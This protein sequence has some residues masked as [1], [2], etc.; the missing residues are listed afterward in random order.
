MGTSVS[1]TAQPTLTKPGFSAR[2]S[3]YLA[4]WLAEQQV[5]LAFSSY[6]TGKLFFVNSDG[7]QLSLFERSFPYCMGLCTNQD[8]S[9]IYL[10][11][12]YQL[13]MLQ[14]AAKGAAE[15][16][17]IPQL[18][19]TTGDLKI[20]DMALDA[21]GQ[22]V[23]VNTLFNGL[24]TVSEGY[25][26][27]PLW[28]PKFISQWAAE[29]RCHLNGLALVDGQPGYVTCI[30]V[31][32]EKHGWRD[33]RATGGVLWHVPSD[34]PVATGLCMPHSPRYYRGKL[35][36]LNAGRGELGYVLPESGRFEVVATCP[37]F[38]RG[39]SFVGDYAIVGLSLPRGDTQFVGLPLEQQ[40]AQAN[41]S[42]Q[43]AI[44]IINLHSG[45]IEH[46]LQLQG[47]VKELYD[48]IALPNTQQATAIGIVNEQI[49]HTLSVDPSAE[50]L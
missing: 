36:L 45:S 10:S 24:A 21:Q 44:Y 31:S 28:R 5:S 23:F 38:V 49:Q 11:S 32:D 1:D 6:Q 37:G 14:D 20:H 33:Q 18:A 48:V 40:L 17:Y 46:Q 12:L 43:C 22:L 39:L 29:D 16:L 2:G 35:W 34:T 8:A 26:F 19:Y 50:M 3:A 27:R 9:R 30:A 7:Q 41:Q 15:R 13:W 25:S 47:V 4:A 42:A